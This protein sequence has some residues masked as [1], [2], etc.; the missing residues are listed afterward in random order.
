MSIELE[1]GHI[2]DRQNTPQQSE[3]PYTA[4]AQ[5]IDTSHD[6]EVIIHRSN[7]HAYEMK[8]D[9]SG[10]APVSQAAMHEKGRI[11][12]EEAE[13]RRKWREY[14]QSQV[15]VLALPTAIE[16]DPVPIEVQEVVPYVESPSPLELGTVSSSLK[17]VDA[18]SGNL[19]EGDPTSTWPLNFNKD[20]ITAIENTQKHETW[21]DKHGIWKYLSEN[22]QNILSIEDILV[23][24]RNFPELYN[25]INTLIASEVNRRLRGA[26]ES[27]QPWGEFVRLEEARALGYILEQI[28]ESDRSALKDKI[29]RDTA[30]RREEKILKMMSE[31]RKP[32]LGRVAAKFSQ[33]L[34]VDRSSEQNAAIIAQSSAISGEMWLRRDEGVSALHAPGEHKKRWNRGRA[35][36]AALGSM[37]AAFAGVFLRAKV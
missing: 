26:K 31:S 8:P 20:V 33:W 5:S 2:Y 24:D 11:A 34:G 7:N 14:L 23:G 32:T 19:N 35:K 16:S 28:P 36:T 25:A 37:A 17:L 18:A 29:L 9:G 12:E 10:F 4:W 3:A 15:G 13:A 6:G 30:Y 21:P 27:E 1:S 22:P